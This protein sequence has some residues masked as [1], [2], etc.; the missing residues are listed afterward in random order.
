MCSGSLMTLLPPMIVENLS[1]VLKNSNICD[2]FV[3]NK[4]NIHFGEVKTKPI[5]FVSKF[6]KKNIKKLNIKYGDMQMKQYSNVKYL[7]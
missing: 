6:K 5:L 7:R 1:G 4:P 3:D 2:W